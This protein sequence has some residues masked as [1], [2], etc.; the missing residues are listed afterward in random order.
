MQTLK[1]ILF[2]LTP[3]ER[4]RAG[5]LLIMILIMAILDTIGVA[6]IMPFI[7]VLTNPEIVESNFLLGIMYNKSKFFGVK[8][9][10]EFIILL[11]F[12]VFFVL[13]ISLTF[14]SLAIY[15]QLRFAQMREYSIGKRLLEGYLSQPYSWSLSRNSADFSKTILS[16]VNLIILQAITPMI[17]LLANATV[18]IAILILLII[19]DPF[20]A[21][22]ISCTLGLAYWIIYKFIRGYLKNIGL[23]RLKVNQLR[24][25]SINEV[26]GAGKEVKLGGLEN[27][28]IDKFSKTTKIFAKH[29]ASMKVLAQLPRFAIEAIGFGGMILFILYYLLESKTFTN[30][31]PLIALYAFGG[32][33]ILPALQQSYNSIS[34]L[35]FAG[36]A[37]DNLC[38]ELRLNKKDLINK[39]VEPLLIERAISLKN[40]SYNYPNTKQT[41]IKNVSLEILA[42]STVG[43]VGATGSGKTTTADIILGLL[44]PQ[45]GVL[46]VDGKVINDHNRKAWQKS[47][48]YVPQYIYL[49]DDTITANIALGIDNKIVSQKSIERAAK[50][51]NLHEF[52]INELPM[53]YKTIV[54]ERGVRLSGGQRQRL[55]IARALYHGPKI[56][57]LDE[58]TSAMDNLTE[59]LIMD[60]INKL[61]KNTTILLIAHRLTT[62]KNCEKIFLIEKGELKDQG[63]YEELIK[64]SSLFSKYASNY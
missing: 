39:H 24:F 57:V 59:K 11:G 63:T 23:E 10:E 45:K 56:L 25:T 5:L 54:G 28:Y 21:F 14:K 22:L 41:S 29:Q 7:A 51:A 26:F 8:N 19:V 38:E 52:I 46:E 32:Y 42:C 18:V 31:L 20:I 33:R 47:I 30:A 49:T 61:K 53:G 3:Q 62:I 50:A 2:L 6:S 60:A 35:R 27:T 40:I 48:G 13:I 17:N 34:S 36:P 55:G 58:A 9:I 44:E 1:K 4:K 64:S 12:L 43:L 16:E 15:A 37:L